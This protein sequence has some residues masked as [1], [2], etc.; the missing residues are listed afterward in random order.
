MKTQF[1]LRSAV[2][3]PTHTASTEIL[4]SVPEVKCTQ[5]NI[6][7]IDFLEDCIGLFV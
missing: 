3:S 1:G 6:D 2:H 4:A 5:T 7:E